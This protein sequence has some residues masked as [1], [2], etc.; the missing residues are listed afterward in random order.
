MSTMQSQGWDPDPEWPVAA[1]PQ[2]WVETLFA[3]M[4]ATYGARFADLWRG[5]NIAQVKRH[6]GSELAKLTSPQ[7]KAGRE[8][9]MALPKPPTL[10]EFLALCRQARMEAAA[11]V[12]PKLEDLP[13]ISPE[14]AARNLG[15]VRSAMSKMR[16]PVP[17]AEWAFKAFEGIEKKPFKVQKDIKDAI[18]SPA[19][20]LVIAECAD[21]ALK[22]QYAELRRQVIDDYRARGLPLWGTK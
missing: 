12:A 20:A 8:N 6:W 5:T 4:S 21:P 15:T 2:R 13:K 1:I 14:E 17:T 18:T 3:T 19:G 7:M 11:H 9:L 10:P 22:S 16:L